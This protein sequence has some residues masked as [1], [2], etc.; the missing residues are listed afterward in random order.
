M[1][2]PDLVTIKQFTDHLRDGVHL[3]VVCQAA[4]LSTDRMIDWLQVGQ[5]ALDIAN[6]ELNSVPES[7]RLEALFTLETSKAV[8]QC[9]MEMV[10]AFKEHGLIK[11][12][13]RWNALKEFLAKRYSDRWGDH[14][15]VDMDVSQRIFQVAVLG[16]ED[17]G[18]PRVEALSEYNGG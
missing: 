14:H 11:R 9:E 8:A 18:L 2:S 12:G 16:D 6:G 17:Q 13:G 5:R 10:K 7:Q 15:T 4:G 3:N 1:K